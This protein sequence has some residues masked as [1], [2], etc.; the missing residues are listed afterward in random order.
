MLVRNY[1]KYSK[2]IGQ[3]N[4]VK[5]AYNETARERKFSFA[6]WFLFIQVLAVRFL[7]TLRSLG[8]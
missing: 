5:L 6:G 2:K 1:V 7:E 4:T 3:L 8:L